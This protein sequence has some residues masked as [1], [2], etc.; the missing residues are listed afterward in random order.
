M[1]IFGYFGLF[2]LKIGHLWLGNQNKNPWDYKTRAQELTSGAI[3]IVLFLFVQIWEGFKDGACEGFFATWNM[4]KI[5]TIFTFLALSWLWM[6]QFSKN[7]WPN[8]RFFDALTDSSE[9]FNQYDPPKILLTLKAGKN[10]PIF[11]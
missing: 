8:Y 11:M 6:D 1:A 10:I 5:W 2:G 9:I 7:R 3:C 4:G